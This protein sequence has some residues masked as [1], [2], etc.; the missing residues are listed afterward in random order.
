[1]CSSLLGDHPPGEDLAVAQDADLMRARDEV[2]SFLTFL[3]SCSA[4]LDDL[5]GRGALGLSVFADLIREMR[6]P[7]QAMTLLFWRMFRSWGLGEGM[8]ALLVLARQWHQV[9]L[10]I[11]RGLEQLR[12]EV[13]AAAE[14]LG[15]EQ[16]GDALHRPAAMEHM[17]DLAR[18]LARQYAPEVEA[19]LARRPELSQAL[20]ASTA[21]L[22]SQA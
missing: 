9:W 22:K 4:S 8:D 10:P 21:L 14:V 2:R 16:L 5:L 17:L 3:E 1:M 18:H 12:E 20:E 15:P 13:P 11:F 7:D 6:P 19:F